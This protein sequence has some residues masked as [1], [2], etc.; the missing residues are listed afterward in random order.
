MKI[1]ILL[2]VFTFSSCGFLFDDDDWKSNP[3]PNSIPTNN[4]NTDTPIKTH[5]AGWIKP[6]GKSKHGVFVNKQGTKGCFE[7]H[8]AGIN[9][10]G[11]STTEIKNNASFCI[12]CHNP[13]I[14]EDDNNEE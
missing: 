4:G 11:I 8:D 7:C 10:I 13:D 12:K 9:T 5:K 6:T 2:M 1:L 14:S 3:I